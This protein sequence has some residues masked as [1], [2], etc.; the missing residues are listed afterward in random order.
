MEEDQMMLEDPEDGEDKRTRLINILTI[1]A[2]GATVCLIGF[3]GLIMFNIVPL[4]APV[5]PPTMVILPTLTTTPT[6]S[7][8]TWTPTKTPTITP[9]PDPDVS[10]VS[11]WRLPSATSSPRR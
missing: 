4:F 6:P 11:H 9:T 8:P 7:I 5:P 10:R 3:Y 1:V 2:L